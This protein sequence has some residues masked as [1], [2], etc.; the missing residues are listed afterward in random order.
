METKERAAI[1][2]AEQSELQHCKDTDSLGNCE[3]NREEKSSAINILNQSFEEVE[4][5]QTKPEV[6]M[7]VCMSVNEALRL[8]KSRP[9]PIPLWKSLWYEGEMSCCFSDSNLGKSIYVVQIANEIAARQKVLYLDL[10]LS[11]KQFQLRY[12]DDMTGELHRFR[13]NFLRAEIN[14]EC[15][16]YEGEFEDALLSNIEELAKKQNVSV[17]I[18][19]NL[20]WLCCNA[21]KGDSAGR[22][23]IAL[24][25]LKQKYGWSILIVAHTPKR[26][27]GTPITP[28]D[29]AGS[30]K[31]Y[32]FFDSVFALGVVGNVEDG[33]RYVIQLKCRYGEF[34]H[35]SN[36][37]ILYQITKQGAWLHMEEQGYSDEATLLLPVPEADPLQERIMQLHSEGKTQQQIAD[38]LTAEGFKVDQSKV[39]RKLRR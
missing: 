27:K 9:N 24:Q 39:S 26:P 30:K 6:N 34:R 12:T 20:T 36:N 16:D 4:Q 10:E 11:A 22:F 14:P 13:D 7:F 37:V 2:T 5:E 38:I 33:K 19:D 15:L 32:N 21:E 35:G 31:L 8:A 29:L 3:Q 25:R 23:M 28:N 18:V 1:T 17:I